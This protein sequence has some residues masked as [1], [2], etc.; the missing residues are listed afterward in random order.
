MEK[1][2]GRLTA[3]QVCTVMLMMVG[4][5]GCAHK[6]A[7]PPD[8]AALFAQKC[9]S[10]HKTNN[11]M[12][13]PEPEAL[14]HMTK[15]T[16]LTALESGRMKWEG[17]LLSS[18][19]KN[20]IA[21]YLGATESEREKLVGASCARDLDPPPDPPVWMGWGANLANTRFQSERSSGLNRERI[22]GLKLKWAFGFPGA[23][24]TYSQPTSF[25]GKVFVGSE[26]GTVYALDAATGCVWW[27]YKAPATVKTAIAIGNHGST[28]FFGDTNGIVYGVKVARWDAGVAGAARG[29]CSGAHHGIAAADRPKTLRTGFVGRRRICSRRQLSMLHISREH[30]GSRYGYGKTTL[31]DIHD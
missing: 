11:D 17:K 23:Y 29:A 18:A 14:R 6:Q 10:C 24:A 26:D 15:A 28:A 1:R 22:R 2:V 3:V 21:E 5:E 9:A 19:K 20:A 30:C 31:E 8:G 13:A 12:R 25:A 4:I 27:M 16:L 7:A